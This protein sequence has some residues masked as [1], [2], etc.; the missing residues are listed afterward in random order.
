MI[1]V[2]TIIGST[3]EGRFGDK[4]GNWV[5]EHVAKREGVSARLVDLRD[6]PMP[7]FDQIMPPATPN[8][9]PYAHDVVRSWTAAIAE[10]DAFV[11]IAAEYNFGPTAVLKNALDWVYPEW[12]H[13]AIGFVSYGSAAGTRSVQQLR[14]AAIEL[15]MAPIR[16]AVHLPRETLMAHFTGGDVA[17]ALSKSDGDAEKM[18]DDLLWWAHALKT[19][20]SQ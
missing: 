12:N 9:E 19:A 2:S 15:Q 5:H 8:R 20:R 10:S 13:K 17:T 6:Y 11:I 4:P 3:R 1:K 16:S 18:I 14:E 7:F